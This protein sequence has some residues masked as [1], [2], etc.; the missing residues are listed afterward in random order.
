MAV[1]TGDVRSLP[2]VAGVYHSLLPADH[3]VG[4]HCRKLARICFIHL[5]VIAEYRTIAGVSGPLVIVDFV[6]VRT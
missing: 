5:H 1:F 2:W 3:G 4:A 6:K